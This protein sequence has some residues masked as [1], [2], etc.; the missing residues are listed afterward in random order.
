MSKRPDLKLVRGGS[1]EEARPPA[2]DAGIPAP[3]MNVIN[4]AKRWARGLD[5]EEVPRLGKNERLLLSAVVRL[6]ELSK[7]QPM[8]TRRLR[9]LLAVK[10]MPEEGWDAP[11]GRKGVWHWFRGGGPVCGTEAGLSAV[12]NRRTMVP[13]G[14]RRCKRCEAAQTSRL[15]HEAGGSKG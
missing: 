8:M 12:V 9:A 10:Q 13:E 15:M 6:F 4:I 1:E 7:K 5:L 11:H 2:E 14:S 3:M